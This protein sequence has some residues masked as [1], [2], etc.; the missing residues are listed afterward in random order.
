MASIMW[1]TMSSILALRLSTE[2][3]LSNGRRSLVWS[4]G[5]R[6]TVQWLRKWTRLSIEPLCAPMPA[7][8]SEQRARIESAFKT[9]LAAL[10]TAAGLP[11]RLIQNVSGW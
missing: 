1:P 10:L 6:N 5:S 7:A 9:L 3:A 4:G 2:T 8:S 11:Y